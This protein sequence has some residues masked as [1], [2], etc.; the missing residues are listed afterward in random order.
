MAK[1]NFF[2]EILQVISQNVIYNGRLA[3]VLFFAL[4]ACSDAPQTSVKNA[5][6]DLQL[7]AISI[8][9]SRL[10][11]LKPK[12]TSTSGIVPLIPSLISADDIQV[13]SC[14]DANG[15]LRNFN[16]FDLQISTI[17]V[18][19]TEINRVI[20]SLKTLSLTTLSAQ[21]VTDASEMEAEVQKILDNTEEKPGF[22]GEG[23]PEDEKD[24]L[25]DAEIEKPQN[26]KTYTC[27]DLPVFFHSPIKNVENLPS[28]IQTSED[29]DG[30]KFSLVN[31]KQ[32]DFGTNKNILVFN[33]PSQKS[34]LR[35]IESVLSRSID[36]SPVQVYI[37][38][39][40][41]EVNEEGM[42]QLGVQ[43]SS[44]TSKSEGGN[45]FTLG[46]ENVV[47]PSSAGA[48]FLSLAISRG[49][50]ADIVSDLLNLKVKALV[51]SGS[52]EVLSRPGVMTLDNRPAV[53]EVGEQK[54]YP[55]VS[56]TSFDGNV[57]LSYD[58]E[59][60]TPGILLQLRPR[61]SE[62]DD[63]VSMEIDVQIKA[64][65]S[66]NDG[67]VSQ[68]GQA[69]ATKPGSSTRRVHTFARVPN[70]SPIIIGGL[71]SRSED[72]TENR[73]PGTRKLGILKNLFG[74]ERRSN[75]KKEVII[76]ITPHIITDEKSLG[77]HSPK[78]SDLFNDTGMNLFRDSYRL[79]DSDVF[80]LD[81][82]YTTEKYKKYSRKALNAVQK[83]PALADQFP[84]SA[85]GSNGFPGSEAVVDKML[86][87]F[88]DRLGLG[89]KIQPGKIIVI[90]SDKTGSFEDVNR[91]RKIWDS[92]PKD[93]SRALKISFSEGKAADSPAGSSFGQV[94][95]VPI[96]EAIRHQVNF[97]LRGKETVIYIKTEKDYSKIANAIA[98]AELIKL[99][100]AQSSL[101]ISD[102]RVGRKLTLPAM[103]DRYYVLDQ[104]AARILYSE[105]FYYS[106][107]EQ[108]LAKAYKMLGDSK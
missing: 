28:T 66:A 91:V 93:G 3:A 17:N 42:R 43:F 94:K 30:S 14:K 9:E 59:E 78:D 36:K 89:E 88:S 48:D 18:E 39:M 56:S 53:I 74:G 35:K 57:E 24:V 2:S 50:D 97:K 70:N 54:Q 27:E 32:S 75:Q 61:V 76:V 96:E 85:F 77:I 86:F 26:R 10:K 5:D 45:V 44:S 51:A 23:E 69:I 21:D 22:L 13:D 108:E 31:L 81:S 1:S 95:I 104:Q 84:Y 4:T 15:Q 101:G 64:L 73:L 100:A 83:N 71:V 62:K 55:V 103:E 6:T 79:K 7:E 87:E 82:V 105:E 60:V 90:G 40:V 106:H 58:F 63:H 98:T 102:I 67:I 38:S 33:H 37:E 41:L 99:N 92:F 8:L 47:A 107:M 19:N 25:I 80:N 72:S 68:D 46:Q 34:K 29:R 65:V 11:Q 52:A 16:L 49:A 12:N 20:T